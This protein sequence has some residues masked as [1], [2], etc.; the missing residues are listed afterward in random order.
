M[1]ELTLNL[2]GRAGKIEEY[3]QY[4][5]N[6]RKGGNLLYDLRSHEERHLDQRPDGTTRGTGAGVRSEQSER[7]WK[8]AR[9]LPVRTRRE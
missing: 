3:K 5:R 4:V 1:P 2:P 9:R 7:G 8:A 6:L